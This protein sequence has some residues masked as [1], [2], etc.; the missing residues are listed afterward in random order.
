MGG[1]I[2]EMPW[3]LLPFRAGRAA[4]NPCP[5]A[6]NTAGGDFTHLMGGKQVRSFLLILFSVFM[7]ATGQVIL[8]MGAGRLGTVFLS[9]QDLLHDIV[10]ILTTPQVLLSFVF[11]AAGF[12]T[13][14]KALTK[15]DLS[16]VYPMAS[17]SYVFMLLY[18]YFLLKEPI[19]ANKF[20]GILLII[21]GVIFINK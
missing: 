1:I 3:R 8:K 14:M 13:W 2:R 21:S 20:I 15:E 17:L 19:T 4:E 16:Y 7:G 11:Y 12:F 18:S 9:R 5:F 6:K 10:R